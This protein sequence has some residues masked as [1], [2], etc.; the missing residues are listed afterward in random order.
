MSFTWSI[1]SPEAQG[2]NVEGLV[3]A[4][5]YLGSVAGHDGA[6]EVVIIRNGQLIHQ[7]EAATRRH[8]I[9]SVTKV[10]TTTAL[11]LL[12][13]QGK[14]E[15]STKAAELYPALTEHYPHV[16]LRHLAAMTSGYRAVGDE[17]RP[18]GYAHGTSFNFTKPHPKP[19]FVPGSSYAYWDSAY[20]LL[21][22]LLTR[23]AG[24]PLQDLL[25]REVMTRLG[26]S[27][28]DW[29]WG[30][31]GR[32][33]GAWLNSGSGNYDQHVTMNALNLA[34]LGLLYLNGGR[35][36]EEQLLPVAFVRDATRVQ[37][38]TDASLGQPES[39]FDGRG[40]YGFG[41]WVQ[42]QRSGSSKWPGVPADTFAA[43]GYNNNDMFILPKFNLVFVRTGLDQCDKAITDTQYGQFLSLLIQACGER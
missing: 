39:G 1:S 22:Y 42:A 32:Y 20:N 13:R 17:P 19:L 8:G 43:S 37:V 30:S 33:G 23:S 29:S 24:E 3:R 31:Y 14:L 21:A 4:L 6:R 2:V 26:I 35:L 9:H 12:I 10:F 38:S 15:L 41:W 5:S 40:C 25:Q 34:K 11:G 16:E 27:K 7:G 18:D 36:R 28:A